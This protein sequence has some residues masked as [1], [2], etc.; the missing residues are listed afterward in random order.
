MVYILVCVHWTYLMHING[1]EHV[2]KHGGHEFDMHAVCAEVVEDQ[3]W[4]MG[5]LL[6]MHPVLL[7]RRHHIFDE[8]ELQKKKKKI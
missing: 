7:Q 2:L 5:E 8:G 1:R 6:V 4:M 3:Q